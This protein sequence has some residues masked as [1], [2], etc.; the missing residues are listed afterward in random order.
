MQREV[1]I[2]WSALVEQILQMLKIN[3]EL[4]LSIF[5]FSYFYIHHVH[6]PMNNTIKNYFMF[7]PFLDS[8]NNKPDINDK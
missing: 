6:K 8:L 4:K 5:Y 1:L 3:V 7:V 2:I